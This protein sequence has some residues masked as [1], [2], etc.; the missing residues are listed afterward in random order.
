MKRI[1]IT[2]TCI[3]FLAGCA[4][5]Y[6]VKVNGYLDSP[7]AQTIS[8]GVSFA[9]LLDKNAKNPIFEKEIKAKIENLLM[10]KGYRIASSE[11]ADFLLDFVYAMSAGRTVTE[12]VPVYHSGDVSTVRIFSRSGKERVAYIDNP[13][14]TT[15][16]PQKYTVYTA[17]LNMG[18]FNAK[19]YRNSQERKE[20][21]IGEA[22]N[23]SENPD[24]RLAINY[25]LLGVFSHFA[26]NTHATVV[27]NIPQNDPRLKELI[28]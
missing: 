15:Y 8:S 14:Y 19:A 13:G 6:H 4:T 20:V 12:V 10:K 26:E 22:S 21:W 17:S 1:L 7:A 23:T 18:V 5:A 2:L 3:I 16:V 27:E 9:V 24:T 28:Y 25:L 11:R